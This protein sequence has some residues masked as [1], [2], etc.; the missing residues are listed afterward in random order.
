MKYICALITVTDIKRS[1]Y[2]YENILKQEVIADY[3]NNVTYKGDFSIHLSSGFKK[4]ID[5][6][7]IKNEANNFELYF[8]NDDVDGIAGMLKEKGVLFVHGVREQPWKQRVIRIYDPDMHIIEIGESM[9]HMVMRLRNT[10]LTPEQI[11]RDT[12]LQLDHVK[13]ILSKFKE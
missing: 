13:D 10:G 9:E 7:E 3:G 6:R 1:R 4:L 12:S 8:E 5:N 11:S 2:F